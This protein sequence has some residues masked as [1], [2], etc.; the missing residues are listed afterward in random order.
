M[1]CLQQILKKLSI[2]SCI[3]GKVFGE[4]IPGVEVNRVDDSLEMKEPYIVYMDS[5]ENEVRINEKTNTAII[6]FPVQKLFFPDM[7]YLEYCL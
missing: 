3:I 5:S 6:K 7:V 2:S 4:T 1:F